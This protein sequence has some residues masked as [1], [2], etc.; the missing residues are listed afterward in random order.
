[1][2]YGAHRGD[3]FRRAAAYVDKISQ[4]AKPD[5]GR[6]DRMAKRFV[7]PGDV[8]AQRTPLHFQRLGKFPGRPSDPPHIPHE[9]AQPD[10]GLRPNSYRKNSGRTCMTARRNAGRH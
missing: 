8:L 1:M 2:S 4:D 3:L 6:V 9:R 7:L 5:D 10:R